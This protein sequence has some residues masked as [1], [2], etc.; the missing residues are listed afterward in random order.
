M[1]FIMNLY[2][3]WDEILYLYIKDEGTWHMYQK[4]L[5]S[6]MSCN[7]SDRTEYQLATHGDAKDFRN[8]KRHTYCGIVQ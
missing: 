5:L 6:L 4:R 3:V 1:H 7:D 2:G 8:E